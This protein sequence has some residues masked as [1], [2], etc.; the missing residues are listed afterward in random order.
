MNNFFAKKVHPLVKKKSCI[1]LWNIHV[2]PTVWFFSIVLILILVLTFKSDPFNYCFWFWSSIV[3]IQLLILILMF[4]SENPT[5]D[6]DFDVQKWPPNFWF[7]FWCSKVTSSNFWFWFWTLNPTFDHVW[8]RSQKWFAL[9]NVCSLQVGGPLPFTMYEWGASTSTIS[10]FSMWLEIL[11]KHG[12]TCTAPLLDA[13]CVKIQL[14][15]DKWNTNIA[16]SV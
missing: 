2:S 15:T 6:F 4:K 9:H 7:W 16:I 12:V 11:K 8:E 14:E 1:R 10:L 3:T 5:F 13:I